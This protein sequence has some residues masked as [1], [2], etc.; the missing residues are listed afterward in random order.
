MDST[1]VTKQ[2]G[3]TNGLQGLISPE[4]NALQAVIEE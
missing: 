2:I 4:Y 3:A 1:T